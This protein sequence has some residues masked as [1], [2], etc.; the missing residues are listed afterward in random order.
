MNGIGRFKFTDLIPKPLTNAKRK[1][2][3]E[4]IIQ[5]NVA[6]QTREAEESARAS[7]EGP[8]RRERMVDIGR[9]VQQAGRQ[10]S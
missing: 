3:S 6:E 5:A 7:K 4:G 9:G 8:S 2:G 10:G 1:S